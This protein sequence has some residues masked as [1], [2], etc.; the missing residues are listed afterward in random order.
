M[1]QWQDEVQRMGTTP[2][3]R[4]S[5]A[6][7]LRGDQSGLRPA[8]ILSIEKKPDIGPIGKPGRIH[9]SA[10]ALGRA[11]EAA[12][13]SMNAFEGVK[14]VALISY[15]QVAGKCHCGKRG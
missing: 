1:A 9:V 12:T 6:G 14:G 2:Q 15:G 11:I 3:L 10:Q 8:G 7:A 5:H 4:P 13:E